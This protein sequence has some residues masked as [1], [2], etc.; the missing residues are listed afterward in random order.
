MKA[1]PGLA[2][3]RCSPDKIRTHS[4]PLFDIVTHSYLTSMIASRFFRRW[5]GADAARTGMVTDLAG[6]SLSPAIFAQVLQNETARG[7]TLPAA[8]R[9]LRNLVVTTL[10]ERDLSG[11]ADLAEVVATMTALGVDRGRHQVGAVGQ[12]ADLETTGGIRYRAVPC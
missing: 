2:A 4:S 1:R 9:R 10:I 3:N 12:S 8:M 11:R 7:L 5:V 6:L